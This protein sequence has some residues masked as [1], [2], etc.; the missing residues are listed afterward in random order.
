VFVRLGTIMLILS[1]GGHW[2]LL[3]TVAWTGMIVSYS[4][5][6]PLKEALT[7]TFDGKHPCCLC[8]AIA[9]A[10]KSERKNEIPLQKQKLEFPPIKQNFVVI[11]PSQFELIPLSNMFADPISRPPLL[12]PP[13]GCFV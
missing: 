12:P 5:R 6:A 7:Y 2:I 10:K 3:Q 4:E 9:A 8:K 11:G 1:T 13:R